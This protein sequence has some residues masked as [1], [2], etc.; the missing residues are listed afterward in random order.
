[1]LKVHQLELGSGATRRAARSY[2]VPHEVAAFKIVWAHVLWR[3]E[4]LCVIAPLGAISGNPDLSLEQRRERHC[5]LEL[6][7]AGR[8]G[9]RNYEDRLIRVERHNNPDVGAGYAVLLE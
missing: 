4:R 5:Q 1:L 9:W 6:S 2:R 3:V 7:H 8:G